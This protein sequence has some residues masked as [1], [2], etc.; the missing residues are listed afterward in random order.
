MLLTKT[1][2]TSHINVNSTINLNFKYEGWPNAKYK[3]GQIVLIY[4]NSPHNK[5]TVDISNTAQSTMS[6]N[7]RAHF[8]YVNTTRRKQMPL[9]VAIENENFYINDLVLPPWYIG[10]LLYPRYPCIN[11][12]THFD[13]AEDEI[14]SICELERY[15]NL[16]LNVTPPKHVEL[17]IVINILKYL[18][19]SY[20]ELDNFLYKFLKNC[21]EKNEEQMLK[22]PPCHVLPDYLSV[23]T[24]E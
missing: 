9:V 22:I 23:L 24:R 20:N 14:I 11:Q 10:C 6:G 2:G 17:D 19:R 1:T 5:T 3:N 12:P 21:H 4:L 15:I 8:N 16:I 18:Y 7:F 13:I